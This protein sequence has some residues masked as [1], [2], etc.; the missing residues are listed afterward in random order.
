MSDDELKIWLGILALLG[1]VLAAAIAVAGTV[2]G[3]WVNQRGV[4]RTQETQ[5][6]IE[7]SRQRFQADSERTKD[8]R[9]LRDTKRSRC[10]DH[11]TTMLSKLREIESYAYTL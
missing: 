10:W 11:Y 6:R 2:L 9:T 8:Q 4:A 5:L 3:A 1:V 7:E